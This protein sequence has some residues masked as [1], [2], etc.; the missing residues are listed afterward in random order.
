MTITPIVAILVVL[1]V[2]STVALA[3]MDALEDVDWSDPG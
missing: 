1:V 2:L 3:M